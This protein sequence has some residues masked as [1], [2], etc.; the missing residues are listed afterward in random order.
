MIIVSDSSPLAYLV[1]IGIADSLPA[2]Y[3]QVYIPPTVISELRHERSPVAVWA[4]NLPD[5]L[6][7]AEPQSISG[8]LMLDRGERESIA[9]AMELGADFVLMDEKKGRATAI[10]RGLKVAGTLAVILDGAS[11]GIFDGLRALQ[12]LDQT[13]FYASAELLQAVRAK[14]KGR[15]PQ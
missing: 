14:L 12:R 7:I 4:N 13:S 5:W 11:R 8:D 9:L 2:L 10:A 6:T 1:E 15:E 3:G